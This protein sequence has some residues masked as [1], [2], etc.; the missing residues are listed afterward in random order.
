[1]LAAYVL[2]LCLLVTLNFPLTDALVYLKKVTAHG[3]FLHCLIL[4]GQS[5]IRLLMELTFLKF[6][7]CQMG[8]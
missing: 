2:I 3:L 7:G 4:Q 5:V 1:M 8:E 6:V